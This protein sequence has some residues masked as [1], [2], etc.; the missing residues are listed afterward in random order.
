MAAVILDHVT[1]LHPN[2]QAAV[3]D[4]S[5]HIKHGEFIVLVGPSGCGKSTTL[6]MICGLDQPTEGTIT[7][8]DRIVNEVPP[9]NRDIAMVFQNY[10]LYPHMTVEANM[11][12]AL[13]L[14]GYSKAEI[15]KRVHETAVMIG[16]EKLLE[17]LPKELSGGQRQRVAVGRAIVR[18]SSVFLFDEPLSNLDANLRVQMRI[19]I[20]ELHKRLGAT[21][22]YVTHDQVEAMTLG[23]R[24]VVMKDGEI[25]QVDTPMNLYSKP[26]N[27]FVASFLG[28]P[29]MNFL[30]GILYIGDKGLQFRREDM[31][32]SMSIGPQF[33]DVLGNQSE[34]RVTL[35]IRPENIGS[36]KARSQPNPLTIKGRIQVIEMLG[37]ESLI[38]LDVEG[39]KLIARFDEPCEVSE[40]EFIE[41]PLL[42]EKISFFDK[43]SGANL[44]H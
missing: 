22:I 39:I 35:G 8:G 38:H 30:D 29:P 43:K 32:S 12:F 4:L 41:V 7:I 21:M 3:K 31:A 10:A 36:L 34:K 2:G 18:N 33:A 23:H 44:L 26:A 13:K 20:H 6:N 14:R 9:K 37:A 11:G 16:L 42:Q 1:K 5:L 28:T 19:E 15:K 25:Q 40:G 27:I 17:R 24:I